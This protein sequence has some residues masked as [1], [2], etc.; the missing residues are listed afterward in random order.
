MNDKSLRTETKEPLQL[1][2]RGMTCAAC[3]NRVER[4]LKKVPGVSQAQVNFATETASV[5]LA[6]EA[7]EFDPGS[8]VS[9]VQDAGYDA[10]LQAEDAPLQEEAQSWWQVWGAVTLGILASL[11]LVLPMLW[12]QHDFWPPWVQFALST[13]VQ[14]ILGARFYKAGWAAL[15]DRSGNMD[16]LVALGTSA[17]WGL[18]VW[19]WL[20][21]D[22]AVMN[23]HADMS[24]MGHGQP[25]LYFESA[26]VVITLV[27]LGKALE[28][29]AKRQTTL[30]IRA[31]QSLRP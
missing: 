3:V 22:P 30:A 10:Q 23:A 13:P 15:K 20:R 25:Q 19:L 16:Q 6:D 11:P 21:H 8:L 26:A 7:C 18:S 5:M 27:L 9:A 29:R 12:G 28:A 1:S 24:D 4:A 17:A 31:L 2:V 14:F